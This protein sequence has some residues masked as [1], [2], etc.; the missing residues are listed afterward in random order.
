MQQDTT[1]QIFNMGELKKSF[2]PNMA[3]ARIFLYVIPVF[4]LVGLVLISQIPAGG[5]GMLLIAGIL[6]WVTGPNSGQR[7]ISTQTV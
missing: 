3:N 7:P 4:I 5:I 6:F 1:G 2:G